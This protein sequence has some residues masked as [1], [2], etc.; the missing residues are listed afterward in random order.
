M[1]KPADEKS[2]PAQVPIQID[3]QPFKV[4]NPVK[5]SHLYAIGGVGAAYELYV[6]ARGP[7]DDQPIENSE[8]SYIMEPGDKLYTAEKALNP[9]R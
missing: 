3:K 5:G 9:G 6:E 2:H 7:G 1:T 8:K 4:E